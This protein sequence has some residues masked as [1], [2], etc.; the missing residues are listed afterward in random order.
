MAIFGWIQRYIL[1]LLSW[2]GIIETETASW[3]D[4]STQFELLKG[5]IN[6]SSYF[7]GND[8]E[9]KP[10]PIDSFVVFPKHL[11][12][13]SNRR[14]F[15]V[16]DDVL[17]SSQQAPAS[18][19][20]SENQ[21]VRSGIYKSS[22]LV[23]FERVER[24]YHSTNF[25]ASQG[26]GLYGSKIVK[27]GDYFY[28]R[29]RRYSLNESRTLSNWDTA[30]Y[31][32]LYS[33]EVGTLP[34]CTVQVLFEDKLIQL[35]DIGELRSGLYVNGIKVNWN[36]PYFIKNSSRDRFQYF[37]D[38]ELEH[39]IQVKREKAMPMCSFYNALPFL[40]LPTGQEYP[41]RNYD[42]AAGVYFYIMQNDL[43]YKYD[44]NIVLQDI[45]HIPF[46]NYGMFYM[47][48]SLY[49]RVT[50]GAVKCLLT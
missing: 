45:Y 7:S 28:G 2:I 20:D 3:D 35:L 48:G 31:N 1:L 8:K 49:F 27:H 11:W 32:S 30:Y 47:N 10:I 4:L 16:I 22:N 33:G 5:E 18:W 24:D 34:Y 17:Y 46:V 15:T 26:L 29:L 39:S 50:S 9:I 37:W 41:Y 40:I 14:Q 36:I 25:I 23:S 44:S 12:M 38:T 13:R 19:A 43:L 42:M 21:R 6:Q